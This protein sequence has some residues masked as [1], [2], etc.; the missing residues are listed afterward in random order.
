MTLRLT[1]QNSRAYWRALMANVVALIDDAHVLLNND[2]PGRARSLLILA[3]EELARATVLYDTAVHAW[4]G[5]AAS[6]ELPPQLDPA[7]PGRTKPHLTVSKN[8]H[9]KIAEAEAY[10]HDLKPFW[11]DYSDWAEP[12]LGPVSR[13]PAD[14][15]QE[16]QAGFYV[17]AAPST[18]GRFGSPL[19]VDGEPVAVELVRV[20]GV[21]EMA[22]I[23]DHTR[24]QALGTAGSADSVQDLHW[25]VLP[26][27][28]PDLWADFA[29]G[30]E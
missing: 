25:L 12:A 14:V 10:G 2:S 1:A 23:S 7:R 3:Q 15:D 19:D 24:M 20:A 17:A 29:G 6:V 28:H 16:K 5:N 30:A 26:Y 11:G 22:L 4:E 9:E 21:A 13:D 8:H 18:G 27:A